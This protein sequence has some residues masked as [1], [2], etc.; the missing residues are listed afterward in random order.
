MKVN[1]QSAE[2][3]AFRPKFDFRIKDH[4]TRTIYRFIHNPGVSPRA[5]YILPLQGKEVCGS[6]PKLSPIW[7]NGKGASLNFFYPEQ[8]V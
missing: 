6:L 1:S 8:I 4:I 5:I 3:Q 2:W 7:G